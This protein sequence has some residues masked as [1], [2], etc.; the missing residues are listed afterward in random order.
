MGEGRR[1][2]QAM[3]GAGI[4]DATDYRWRKE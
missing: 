2:Q 3:R 4:A 1:L